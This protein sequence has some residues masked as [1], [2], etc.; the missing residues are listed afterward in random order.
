MPTTTLPRRARWLICG[1]SAYAL[2][3]VA[4]GQAGAPSSKFLALQPEDGRPAEGSTQVVITGDPSKPG[5]YVVQNTFALNGAA[6][7]ITTTRTVTSPSS[8]GHGGWLSAP[9]PTSTIQAKW[10][11]CESRELCLPPGVRP[12]L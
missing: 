6:A 9:S 4:Y 11:Q 3:A 10:C 12:P 5:M 1:L 2:S 8:R 7:P